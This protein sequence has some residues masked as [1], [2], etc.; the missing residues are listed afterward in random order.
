MTDGKEW[1]YAL[2]ARHAAGENLN[3]NQIRC[4]RNALGLSAPEK[5]FDALMAQVNQ[6]LHG[7]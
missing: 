7:S 2:Q 6:R 1:A 5:K 3:P 4:Y